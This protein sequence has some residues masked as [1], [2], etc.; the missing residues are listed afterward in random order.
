M[1]RK[2][3]RIPLFTGDVDYI[4]YIDVRKGTVGLRGMKGIATSY[5]RPS[6]RTENSHCLIRWDITILGHEDAKLSNK[7]NE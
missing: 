1:C 7:T 6:R 4:P 2:P 5:F 3:L